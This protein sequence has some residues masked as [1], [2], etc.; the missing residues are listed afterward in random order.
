MELKRLRRTALATATVLLADK[1]HLA[2]VLYNLIDNAIKY[3]R[4]PPEIVIRTTN[5]KKLLRIEVSDQGVGIARENHKRI[6][7]KFYRVPTGNVHDVKGFGLGLHYVKS[8]VIAHRGTISVESAP[9]IGSA[10][11]INL[12]L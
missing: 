5:M 3:C 2:N 8:F 4:C 6:F 10:F 12:P 11:T 7:E 1:L 9:G